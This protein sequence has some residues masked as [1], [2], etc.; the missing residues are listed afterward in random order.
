MSFIP[1]FAG[2]FGFSFLMNDFRYFSVFD[3]IE[4]DD[5]FSFFGVGE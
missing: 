2:D 3:E 4:V 5:F 1:F